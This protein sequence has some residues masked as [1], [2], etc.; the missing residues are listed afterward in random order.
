MELDMKTEVL[1]LYENRTDVTLTTY[2][3][4]D[5]AELLNG[6]KRPIVLIC[7][8]GAYL[9]C[10]D[11]EAEPVAMAFAAMGYHTAVLRYS[12]YGE[13]AFA[14][15]FQNMK[16]KPECCYPAQMREIGHAVMLLKEHS[17]EWLIDDKK[18]I[19]CGFSAGA[20]N[21]AMYATNWF[22]PIITEHFKKD[23]EMFR[24]AACILGYCLSDYVYMKENTT[25]K[26]FFEGSNQ[27]FLGTKTP[28]DELLEQVS[29]ARNVTK[30]TPPT[31]LWATSADAMVPVQHSLR[32][33]HALADCHVPFE[34]HVFE[35]GPHGLSLATQAS[36]ASKHQ[37]YPDAAKWVGLVDA[38]LS[39]RFALDL[40]D[41]TP[42]E[43]ML[44]EQTRKGAQDESEK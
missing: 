13:E 41:M 36:A 29:P 24:P 2:I 3:L 1:H 27:A 42:F 18:V 8:G 6:G 44:A 30:L 34:L 39:K 20:H 10:S 22:R 4:Q 14:S 5:S 38:W 33:A 43:R 31:F 16:E 28:S 40:P 32:M 17:A 37:I 7:P 11:R 23:Q 21:C 9:S 25:D 19:I 12:T 15:G 26:L 35:E